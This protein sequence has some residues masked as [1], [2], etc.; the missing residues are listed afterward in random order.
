MNL[1]IIQLDPH[2]DWQ[3]GEEVVLLGRQAGDFLEADDLARRAGTI[4][5]ELFCLLGRLNPRIYKNS[6]GCFK[7]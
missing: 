7:K 1:T 4:S 5:Y 3:V 2:E 6:R